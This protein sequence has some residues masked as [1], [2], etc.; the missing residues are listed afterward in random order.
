MFIE[1]KYWKCYYSII[2][3]RKANPVTGYV[4]KHHI[5][6]RSLGGNNK[7][8]NI[9]ALTAREHFICHR[10]LVKMTAGKDKMKMSYAIRCLINQENQHQQRY[11]ITSRTYDAIIA[12]TRN[13]ISEY[14]TG[15]NNPYY[16]KTH[17]EEVRTKMR[18]KRALQVMPLRT[19]KVYSEET[20]QKWREGNKKQFEDPAQIEMRRTKCNKIQG[21]KL[22]HNQ[23]GKTKYYFENNQPDGWALGR[24]T[25]KGGVI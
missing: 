16:G 8:E 25:K 14:Q 19:G 23:L 2:A 24:P 12:N 22:Y 7:K 20:I 4:E 10:L 11:K 5:I 17:S 1:N 15:E 6:P 13:S 18:A 21:M 9:V 3:K